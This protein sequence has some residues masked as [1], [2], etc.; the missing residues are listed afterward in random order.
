MICIIPIRSKSKG[1]KN[2][3]IK[4]LNGMPL[5]MHSINTA[6]KSKIFNKI[7]IATIA[8]VEIVLALVIVLVIN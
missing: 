7:I 4:L 3:N 8:I 2:K 6:L 1:L 5:V